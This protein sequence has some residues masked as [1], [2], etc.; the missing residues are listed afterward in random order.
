MK[1]IF[2]NHIYM[3]PINDDDMIDES[4]GSVTLVI[5]RQPW[6]SIRRH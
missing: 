5:T 1:W 3:F 2:R 6:D 4:H